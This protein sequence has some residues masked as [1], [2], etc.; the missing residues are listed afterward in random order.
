[1]KTLLGRV[2]PTLPLVVVGLASLLVFMVMQPWWL[3]HPSTPTGGD[4]GSHVLGPAFLRDFLL[5]E[6]RVMGW[7]Q[8]WF[9]GFPVFYFYF[10][11]PSLVI[12]LLDVFIPYGAAFKL[13][14][15]VGLV[16]MAPAA[17]FHARAIK[18][19]KTVATIAACSA[20]VFIF[21]ESF[22]I[23]GGNMAS[24]LAGEFSFAWSFSLSLVYLGFLVKAVADDRKYV[25]W[26]ALFLGLTALTHILTTIVALRR[27]HGL[28]PGR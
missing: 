8:D 11:I 20:V 25:K 2:N 23:Y 13:V 24:S 4:M 17:Y 21:F 14:T 1:M 6:G 27:Q 15:T 7:S 5:P 22:T 28:E 26:A 18:L 3:L 10:P 9:A 12:V 19:P 16:G